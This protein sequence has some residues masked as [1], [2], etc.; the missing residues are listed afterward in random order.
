M[1]MLGAMPFA[2]QP[3]FLG[4]MTETLALAPDQ[5]GLMASADIF[6]CGVGELLWVLVDKPFFSSGSYQA[7][8]NEHGAWLSRPIVRQYVRSRPIAQVFRLALWVM[9]L[10]FRW[11]PRSCVVPHIQIAQSPSAS[12]P[13]LASVPFCCLRYQKPY[14]PA[15]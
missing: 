1:A 14:Q 7:R 11:E 13:K 3:F 9:A 4:V 12:L 5:V 15:I 8:F 10:P 2:V 6:G